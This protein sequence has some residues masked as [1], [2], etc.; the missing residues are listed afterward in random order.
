MP[1]SLRAT[2]IN[3]VFPVL[4]RPVT[5]INLPPLKALVRFASSIVE[6]K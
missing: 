3:E 5:A 2:L 1:D 4:L 6:V